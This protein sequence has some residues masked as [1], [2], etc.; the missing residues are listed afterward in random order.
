MQVC[1]PTTPAQVFAMIRRQQVRP[2]RRPLI[3]MTPKSL[4]RHP[5]AVSSMEE[6]ASG[7]YHNII[8]E[9][10]DITPAD[11]KRVVFC[12][13]KVYYDLLEQRR[14]NEQKDVVIVRVEQL[15]P[16]PHEEMDEI[17]E[18]YEHVKD[19]VWCQEEPQ[20]QGAWYCSQHHFWNSIPK[21]ATLTYAGRKAS[22]SPAVGYASVHAKE[23]QALVSDALTI[24]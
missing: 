2:M 17:V 1:V 22:S 12:S 16:F 10:D 5:L 19:F 4:L 15:Y 11:V 24:K 20:N 21:G 8:D 18:K 7:V 14:K 13:G 9:V 3:V 23:Q 6:I